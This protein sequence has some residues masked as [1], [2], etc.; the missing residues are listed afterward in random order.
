MIPSL[1]RD[2]DILSDLVLPLFGSIAGAE[3]LLVAFADDDPTQVTAVMAE[4]AHGT[5]PRS[6][7]KNV[8]NPLAMILAGA[9]VLGY[10]DG[11]EEVSRAIREASLEAIAEGVRTAD[12]AGQAGTSEFTDE[13]IR[14][15]KSKLEV[16]STLN[17]GGFLPTRTPRP[18]SA[19]ADANAR[20]GRGRTASP[21]SERALHR[22]SESSSSGTDASTS[23]RRTSPR[24]RGRA[25]RAGCRRRGGRRVSVSV[26]ALVVVQDERQDRLRRTEGAEHAGACSWM[27]THQAELLLGQ[28]PALEQDR[29]RDDELADVVQ[30]RAEAQHGDPLLVEAEAARHRL[31]KDRDARRMAA[32]VRVASFDRRRECRQ[33]SHRTRLFKLGTRFPPS[34]S[35]RSMKEQLAAAFFFY[36]LV[37]AYCLAVRAGSRPLRQPLRLVE[38]TTTSSRSNWASCWLA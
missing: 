37:R 13:V 7:G 5:A 2:G 23:S 16:W 8:A 19:Q 29:R 4:A 34:S 36:L 33:A 18:A 14:R 25:P 1:N 28:R 9:A 15:T 17:R 26:P 30:Q 10:A 11:A 38:P 22:P 32:R 24:C 20:R 27:A 6:S 35:S 31:R 21:R 12:L 3:S